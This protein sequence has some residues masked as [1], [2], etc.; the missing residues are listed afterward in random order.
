MRNNETFQS[1]QTPI[2]RDLET[3]SKRA[4]RAG[5]FVIGGY[6]LSQVI[7]LAGNIILTRLLVPEMFAVMA[8]GYVFFMGLGLLSD[9]GLE[10]AI[11][12]STRASDPVFLNTAWTLQAIRGVGIWI[13][14][15][16]VAVPVAL[17]YEEEILRYL[18]PVIG[19][20][21]VAQG[22]KSTTLVTLN[23]E[24]RQGIL[25]L[26]EIVIQAISL[27]VMVILAYFFRTVWSLAIGGLVS[28]FII[29]GWSHLL[30]TDVRNRF[31]FDRDAARELLSFGKWIFFSTA[32]MFVATQ[33][34]KIML[35]RLF[36]LA[37]F[38]VY[39]VA[40]NL[41]ELPKQVMNAIAGKVLMPLYSKYADLP[42]P[43]LRVT[44]RKQRYMLVLPLA[45]L[46]AVLYS[47][48]DVLI[49]FLYDDR[50]MQASWI[51]P[52]LALGMWPLVLHGTI[53]RS[54]YVVGKPNYLTYGNLSKF[55]YMIVA[56]PTAHMLWGPLGT[57]IVVVLNDIPVYLLVNL[58]LKKEGLGVLGQDAIATAVLTV[59]I[60]VFVGARYLLDLGLPGTLV[61]ISG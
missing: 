20:N 16:G 40:V 33:M 43:D 22:L 30:P 1:P 5:V 35:G 10:P 41:A 50:Y 61:P 31:R 37:F 48:G 17:F 4:V 15:V 44:I 34:D 19:L 56:I 36:P 47:F 32:L 27:V 7:R 38:G 13:L 11:I 46:V 3:H 55:V 14:S 6:G 58:G 45:L 49:L 51:F 2:V 54:L 12:R 57:V 23:K 18:I 60:G 29:T 25:T 52:L 39:T 42:R 9:I 24:M 28:N 53:D 26:M 21:A 8:I 59:F